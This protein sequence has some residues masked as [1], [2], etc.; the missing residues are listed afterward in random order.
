MSCGKDSAPPSYGSLGT[1]DKK[2]VNENLEKYICA[3]ETFVP[4]LAKPVG[5]AS[6]QTPPIADPF[7]L[8]QPVIKVRSSL[9]S[10]LIEKEYSLKR[11]EREEDS[12]I[13]GQCEWNPDK[14]TNFEMVQFLRWCQN[15]VKSSELHL[16]EVYT[17]VHENDYDMERAKKEVLG[18]IE[19]I[20]RQRLSDLDI[21][22]IHQVLE[23]TKNP[24]EISE[25]TGKK[26]HQIIDYLKP[27]RD[28][29]SLNFQK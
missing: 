7:V 20:Q 3:R 1:D 8:V 27:K 22:K 17:V 24:S 14:A 9:S 25:M 6:L 19:R 16:E 12:T 29:V 2:K 10:P 23:M 21:N 26:Y 4:R 11:K 15:L 13:Y 28:N 18:C 5:K